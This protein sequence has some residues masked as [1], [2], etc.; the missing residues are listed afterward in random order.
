[1]IER[2]IAENRQ[3]WGSYCPVLQALHLNE[4]ENVI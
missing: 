3:S 1:M 4:K 2:S